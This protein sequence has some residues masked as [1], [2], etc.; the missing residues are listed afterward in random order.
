MKF[1]GILIILALATFGCSDAGTTTE[2]T[3]PESGSAANKGKEA[4]AEYVKR[5]GAPFRTNTSPHSAN[6]AAIEAAAVPKIADLDASRASERNGSSTSF[7]D[8]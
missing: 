5:D 8:K 6:V 3:P 1:V 4:M 7:Q 2:T